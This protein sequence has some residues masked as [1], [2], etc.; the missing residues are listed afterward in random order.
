MSVESS[1]GASD[2]STG[3][4]N[5]QEEERRRNIV[6]VLPIR[7][8]SRVVRGFGRGSKDLGIPTANL[9]CGGGSGSNSADKTQIALAPNSNNS[10]RG[11]SSPT[12][13]DL[14]TGIYWGFCRIGE[15]EGSPEEADPTTGPS[16]LGATLPCAVSI[17]YNPTY[18]NDAK[19]IEPHLIAPRDDPRRHASS[20][21]ETLYSS[22]FCGHPCRLSVAGY[23]R[24]E[25]PFEGL[26]KLT[27]A[28]K[29]DIAEA[30]EQADSDDPRVRAER[31]W[32][33]SY[34]SVTQ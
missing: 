20:C 5:P 7:I 4:A 26:D 9:A 16:V 19:T 14:P 31:D 1:P 3:G 13:E 27:L 30:E 6:Q 22:D 15:S 10:A 11:G 8:V 24:P 28:I 25:L 2:P 32:V 17:G 23:L 34:G 29:K 21:Q 33:A 18:G 12:L